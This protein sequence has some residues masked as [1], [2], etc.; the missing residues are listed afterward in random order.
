MA[1]RRQKDALGLVGGLGR[2]FGPL[3]FI[4]QAGVVNRPTDLP[5]NRFRQFHF[6]SCKSGGCLITIYPDGAENLTPRHQWDDQQ[7]VRLALS[8][9][10]VDLF[11]QRVGL[12]FLDQQRLLG[13]DHPQR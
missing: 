8:Q 1:H 5:G 10:G 3:H 11:S 12:S 6:L 13:L 9:Q 7:R 4:E 2:L